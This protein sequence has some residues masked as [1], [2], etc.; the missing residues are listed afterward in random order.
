MNLKNINFNFVFQL[1]AILSLIIIYIFQ[2]GM[3]ITTPSLRTG[4]DFMAFYS[5]GRVAQEYG[6]EN[7]YKVLLQ[8]KV[9]EDILGFQ[10]A[11]KQVLVYNHVPYLIPILS[12]FVS[13]NYVV[14]FMIWGIAMLSIY[15][16]ASLL[17]TNTL[18]LEGKSFL[19]GIGVFLFYPIFE[20]LLL[21]QDTALLFFGCVLW[22]RGLIKQKSWLAAIGL[23]LTSIRP[24]LFLVF[25]IPFFLFDMKIRWKLILCVGLLALIS[26]GVLGWQGIIDFLSILQISTTG[27]WYGFHQN[28]MFNLMG[29]ISRSL[30][31]LDS[32][33]IRSLGWVGYF[34]SIVFLI[35][36]WKKK[37]Q[38]LTWLV[39]VTIILSLFFAP[40]LHYH[41]LTLLIIPILLLLKNHRNNTNI[42]LGIS[43][44]LLFLKSFY[45][46]LP[47]V[48]YIY[49][50]L[51][52][53]NF[54]K[55]LQ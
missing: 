33:F 47:Y 27:N 50:S 1:V 12:F 2:W 45:Y 52:I 31:F 51:K 15:A 18:P 7:T 48:L 25:A 32:N 16:I 26:V 20:S 54:N 28:A 36:V 44:A 46:I 53:K 23:A 10:L 11:D 34:S 24:H 5:A 6:M 38:N 39:C 3:M 29:F 14:S 35:L 19:G 13:E 49:L 40:H 42:I 55:V 41:D 21:G 30:P 22:Y 4:T 37:I 9:Q 43:L 17:L 8:Q